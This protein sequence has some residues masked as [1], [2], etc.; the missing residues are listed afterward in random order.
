[1][2]VRTAASNWRT[3]YGPAPTGFRVPPNASPVSAA[4]LIIMPGCIA[5]RNGIWPFG[6]FRVSTT[7]PAPRASIPTICRVTSWVDAPAR[8]P[9]ATERRKF[10]A[11]ASASSLTPS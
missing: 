5:S 1:M 9:S 10:A 4:G 11:T 7:V 3:L 2:T 6:S 8:V